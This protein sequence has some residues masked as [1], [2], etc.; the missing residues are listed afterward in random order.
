MKLTHGPFRGYPE[1]SRFVQDRFRD[2]KILSDF[3]T[4]EQCTLEY[5]PSKGKLAN[6]LACECIEFLN[7]YTKC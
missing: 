6:I 5:D 3:L 1:Y 4:V 7:E 2:T